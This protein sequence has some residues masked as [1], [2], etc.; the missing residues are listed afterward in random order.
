MP[1]L[2]NDMKAAA[3]PKTACKITVRYK[4]GKV[5]KWPAPSPDPAHALKRFANAFEAEARSDDED[6]AEFSRAVC[7][8]VTTDAVVWELKFDL[9]EPARKA[10]PKWP[11]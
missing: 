9:Q 11:K 8:N 2:G 3:Q 1:S 10:A 6:R 5:I 7:K 4:S